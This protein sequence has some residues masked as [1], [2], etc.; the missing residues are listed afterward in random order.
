MCR[1]VFLSLIA[2]GLALGA[3]ATT[4]SVGVAAPAGS[5]A[6]TF[7]SS[8]AATSPG[9]WTATAGAGTADTSVTALY[10]DPLSDSSYFAYTEGASS[11]TASYAG[12]ITSFDLL[13]GSPDAFNTITFSGPGG[14]ESYSPGSGLLA[15]LIPNNSNAGTMAVLFTATPGTDWTS[16]M[17]TSSLNSFEFGEVSFVAAATS[18]SPSPEPASIALLAGG[19][20]AIGALRKRKS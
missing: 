4:V 8:L 12:G 13:W 11:I 2:L 15:G 3:G 1:T 10:L 5:S 17:F 19:F 7:G 6:V 16:V 20:L 9:V 14:T 18:S